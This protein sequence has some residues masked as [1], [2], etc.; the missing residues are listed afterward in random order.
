MTVKSPIPYSVEYTMA[1]CSAF[2]LYRKLGAYFSSYETFLLESLSGDSVDRRSNFV[3]CNP[4]LSLAL[5]SE[6]EVEWVG[7]PKLVE[8]AKFELSQILSLKKE[9]RDFSLTDLIQGWTELFPHSDMNTACQMSYA[10]R[11]QLESLPTMPSEESAPKLI[12]T[13]FQTVGRESIED[14]GKVHLASLISPLWKCPKISFGILGE[15]RVERNLPT[16]PV[17]SPMK[18]FEVE[19]TCTRS[20]YRNIV[21][22]AKTHLLNGDIY[23]VQLGHAIN[24][25]TLLDPWE[26]YLRLRNRNPSPYCFMMPAGKK[27]LVGASPEMFVRLT[28]SNEVITRPIAGTYPANDEFSDHGITDDPKELAEHRMLLD[29]ARN[30]I[31]R[32]ASPGSLDVPQVQAVVPYSHVKHMVSTVVCRAPHAVGP[33]QVMSEMFPAGTMT[34]APKIRAMEIINDLEVDS[35]EFYSGCVGLIGGKSVNLG[36]AIR[37]AT[38]F[39][40]TYSIRASAGIVLDSDPDSEWQETLNKMAATYWAICDEELV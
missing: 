2:D 21:E 38:H 1:R 11:L 29:L 33:A 5:R 16:F 28:E 10:A 6:N 23:Q 4:I 32:L 30:D 12:L 22:K 13:L 14:P 25:K 34:G 24:I 20:H 17:E 31:C 18:P 8:K 27:M 3:G 19:R 15:N 9:G 37:C 40:Q 39:D 36:L 26:F 7:N 35:R